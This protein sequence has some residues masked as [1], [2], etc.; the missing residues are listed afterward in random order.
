MTFLLDVNVLFVLHQPRHSSYA[1]VERWFRARR[2]RNFAF[3]TCPI[4]QAGMLRLLVLGPQGLAAFSM[5][6]A[7]AALENLIGH[8][9][10]VYWPD[11]PQYLDAAAHLVRRMQGHRQITDA[12]LVGLAKHHEG[13]L[14]TLDKAL[15]SL[16]S[17]ELRETVELI[18]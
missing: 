15:V 13:K 1:L 6:E 3:A 2:Q 17:P 5:D 7:K 11:E 10:H 9:N 4:T 16:A 12:Y 18:V 8:Q 14:A